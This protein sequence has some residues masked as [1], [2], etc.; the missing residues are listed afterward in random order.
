MFGLLWSYMRNIECL[1]PDAYIEILYKVF[2]GSKKD[3]RSSLKN[4]PHAPLRSDAAAASNGSAP[5]SKFDH[6]EIMF[7]TDYKA[8]F[9]DCQ[10]NFMSGFTK[11]EN[12]QLAF[13]MEAVPR[14]EF[15][16]LGVRTM[17]KVRDIFYIDGE[18]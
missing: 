6:K 5:L 7:T 10:S 4:L 18:N 8:L 15:Y 11:D 9:K 3:R 14:D 13:K 1:T 2:G 17:Y 12:T 16:P